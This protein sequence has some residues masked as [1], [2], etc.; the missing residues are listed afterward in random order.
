MDPT[1]RNR[2]Y[3]AFKVKLFD[4]YKAL[5][6]QN[7]SIVRGPEVDKLIQDSLAAGQAVLSAHKEHIRDLARDVNTEAPLGSQNNPIDLQ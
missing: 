3:E 5:L 6:A 4:G 2:A 7:K 1:L